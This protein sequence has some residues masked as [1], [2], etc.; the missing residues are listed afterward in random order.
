MDSCGTGNLLFHF[1]S[2]CLFLTTLHTQID[3]EFPVFVKSLS[4]C[5]AICAHRLATIY[6]LDPHL[7]VVPVLFFSGFCPQSWYF[8]PHEQARHRAVAFAC[9]CW[10]PHAP[11]PIPTFQLVQIRLMNVRRWFLLPIPSKNRTCSGD[12][13][14]FLR[15]RARLWW[16]FSQQRHPA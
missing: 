10:F 11:S 5:Q 14:N 12:D 13:I 2:D 6:I 3:R 1:R 8:P 4:H 15:M 7:Q 9:H 16:F